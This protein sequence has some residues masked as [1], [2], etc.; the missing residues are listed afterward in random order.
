[1]SWLIVRIAPKRMATP[2][3]AQLDKIANSVVS[4]VRLKAYNIEKT[5]RQTMMQ[6]RY[7]I[8]PG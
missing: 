3:A 8:R 6:A 4:V 2:A 5:I 7:L 1:M